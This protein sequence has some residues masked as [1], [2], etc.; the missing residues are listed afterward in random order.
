[1]VHVDGEWMMAIRAL[2]RSSDIM[3]LMKR[4]LEGGFEGGVRCLWGSGG[5]FSSIF[6]V[7]ASMVKW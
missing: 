7:M 2:T 5:C 1:M 6:V 4:G 3:T